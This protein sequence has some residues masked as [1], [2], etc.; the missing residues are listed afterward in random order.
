MQR[1]RPVML[2]ILDGWG[3]REDSADNAVRQARTPNFDRLWESCP[4]AFL[5]TSG[6][7]VEAAWVELLKEE[8]APAVPAAA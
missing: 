4:H 8:E 2:I 7:D 6:K 1:R 3:W 5:R